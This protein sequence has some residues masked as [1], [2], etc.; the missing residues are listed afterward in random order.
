MSLTFPS[1]KSTEMT[2]KVDIAGTSA[3]PST[4]SVVL[5]RDNTSLSYHAMKNGDDWTAKIDRPGL[6]FGPGEVRVSIN[7]LLNSRLFTPM[8]SK[9]VIVESKNVERVE[10]VAV[11]EAIAAIVEITPEVKA[12]KPVEKLTIKK[13][14][15][16]TLEESLARETSI[17]DEP[18]Q[19]EVFRV[20]RTRTIYR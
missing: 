1:D 8:K 4:V 15:L 3:H 16:Q 12:E 14:L 13:P 9:A 19:P 17:M 18:K 7:V 5:E 20:R 11:T 6:V 2:F 10:P